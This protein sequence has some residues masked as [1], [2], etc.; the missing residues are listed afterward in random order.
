[1]NIIL[2]S[3]GSGKR[4]WPLSNNARSKQFLKLLKNKEGQ[5]ESMVQRVFRQM[6]EADIT[7]NFVVATGASQ[8]DSIYGQLGNDVDVVVEPERR[9]TFPAISLA[10]SY[11]YLKKN[12]HKDEVV[13]V[14]PVDPFAELEYFS[15][16]KKM[17]QLIEEGHS[18]MALMGIHPT[19]PSE[20]YG[21]ILPNQ[22]SVDYE[23]LD[24][25]QVR[26]FQEKPSS[27][28][29]QK[30]IS[31]GAM[32]NGGVFAFKLGYLMDIIKQYTEI[33]SFEGILNRYH[34]LKKISFDYEVVEKAKSIIMVPYW[35]AW[36]DLG[37]WNTL[38][39]EIEESSLGYTILGEGT[40]NST[41]INETDLPLV[42]LGAE[43]MVVAASPDGILVSDKEKSSYLKPYVDKLGKRPMYEERNWGDY[44]ILDCSQYKNGEKSLTKQI[45]VKNG[46]YTAYQSH[47]YRNE[48]WIILNGFGNIVV[49]GDVSPL[50]TGDSICIK[51]GQKHSV[52]AETDLYYLEIQTGR[53]LMDEDVRYDKWNW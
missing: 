53:K 8:V 32:W 38:T 7:A 31:Q 40:I 41:V 39:E 3:G 28:E 47:Q 15:V 27:E 46:K 33:D 45:Y 20:K 48:I 51:A 23:M 6:K 18:E 49:D 21:Y 11:L 13:L 16:L 4:L 22:N 30:L 25:F 9:D 35:G 44:K 1:M 42:V 19:Y 17:G 29:A 50:K 5:Y 52:F 26:Y 43:N 34:T 14:L 10:A 2:L 24:F 36:K 37:T 12:I